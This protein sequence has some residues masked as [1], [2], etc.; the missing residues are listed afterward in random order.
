MANIKKKLFS[1]LA[2]FMLGV[3]VGAAGLNAYTGHHIDELQ[4]RLRTLEEQLVSNQSEIKQLK[5]NLLDKKHP[6]LSSIN[7]HVT[8]NDDTLT[9][10]EHEQ[11]KIETVKNVKKRLA[12]LLGQELSKINFLQVAPI[13][14]GR[15]ITSNK[16]TFTQKVNLLIVR[17]NMDIYITNQPQK[18]PTVFNP[19]K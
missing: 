13:I 8:V 12:T 5:L 7:V 2:P 4:F 16:M 10:L 11:I 9:E 3:S 17:T 18:K 1:L 14:D 15:E 6:V 19:I